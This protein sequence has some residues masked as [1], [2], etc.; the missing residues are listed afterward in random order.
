MS[1][2][3]D[4]KHLL[5]GKTVFCAGIYGS[6]S[7][8]VYNVCRMLISAD[9]QQDAVAALYADAPFS[10]AHPDLWSGPPITAEYWDAAVIKMHEGSP[11]VLDAIHQN[12]AMTVITVR[13]PRDAIV[14]VMQRFQW[15]FDY[16]FERVCQSVFFIDRIL[17]ERSSLVLRYEDSFMCDPDT[18][19]K[20]ASHLSISIDNIDAMRIFYELCP[21]SIDKITL[22]YR[23][24][25]ESI[26]VDPA[27]RL[28]DKTTHWHQQHLGDGRTG[29]WREYLHRRERKK[30]RD[31]CWKEITRLGYAGLGW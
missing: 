31:I 29:K 19:R 15:D 21:K 27:G 22:G 24:D 14:S 5:P 17:Q 8:W 26:A 25:D 11:E 30:I 6:A 28:Y 13:D 4:G 1:K 12:A 18:I 3:Q 10:D 23:H 9:S 2:N 20:I 7:T 16:A